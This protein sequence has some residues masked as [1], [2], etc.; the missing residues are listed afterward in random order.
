MTTDLSIVKSISNADNSLIFYYDG[1]DNIEYVN[2]YY[3]KRECVVRSLIVTIRKYRK[4][5][6]TKYHD[7]FYKRVETTYKKYMDNLRYEI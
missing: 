3:A 1:F 4:N 5:N 7:D 2:P 6:L